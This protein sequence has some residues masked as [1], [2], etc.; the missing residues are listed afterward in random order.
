MNFILPPVIMATM[1]GTLDASLD[2]VEKAYWDCEFA[3]VQGTISFN[4]FA[5]CTD[6]Y[7]H[8]KKAKFSGDF[9][10]LLVWWQQH[11]DREMSLRLKRRQP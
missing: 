3:A 9:D 4:E 10:K 1:I 2:E 11:K 6:L 7:E 8:L 5:S